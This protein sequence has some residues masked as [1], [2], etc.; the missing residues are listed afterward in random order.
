MNPTDALAAFEAHRALLFGIAYRMLGSA[1]D[2]EDLLQE[3]RLRWLKGGTSEGVGSVRAFLVTVVSRLCLDQL[4]SARARR[5][6]YVGPWLPEPIATTSESDPEHLSMAFLLLLERLTPQ[7]RAA[8]LLSEVFDYRHAEVAEVLGKSEEACRQLAARARRAVHGERRQQVDRAE[9]E[10][11]L[12]AFVGAIATGDL[13][14]LVG[15]LA[16][17]AVAHSDGGG[18]VRAARK[19]VLGADRV[20]RMLIGLAGKGAAQAIPEWCELNGLP[21]IRLREAGAIVS[22]LAVE[23]E[24]GVVRTVFL[25][26]NPDKL[27]HADA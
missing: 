9:H 13:S 27:H 21:A 14:S 7:E 26:N 17:D 18:R 20:G 24:G 5:E 23:V 6:T 1:A 4:D 10:R 25:V 22:V 2:A 8:F 3:A 15:L 11:V 12:S 16:A 19:V